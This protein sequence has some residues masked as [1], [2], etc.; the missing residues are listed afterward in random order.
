M[1]LRLSSIV[2]LSLLQVCSPASPVA[3]VRAGSGWN[4]PLVEGKGYSGVIVPAQRAKGFAEAIGVVCDYW[5]PTPELIAK[6]ES[7]LRPALETA[8][9]SPESVTYFP[10]GNAER[11]SYVTAEL[12]KTLDHFAKYKRQ[13]VG[14]ILPDGSRRILVNCFD[15]WQDLCANWRKRL[16]VV[17]GGGYHFWRIQFEV[18]TELFQD[19]ESNGHHR[20]V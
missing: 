19:F 6:L 1:R 5:T 2:A 15:C 14:I 11:A 17:N 16:V 9:T 13:Y 3:L 18:A 20:T 4:F 12:A 8:V 7:R 10:A